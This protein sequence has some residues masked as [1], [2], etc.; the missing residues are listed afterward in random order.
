MDKK[1]ANLI[2]LLDE[3]FNRFRKMIYSRFGINLTDAKKSLFHTR[4]QKVLN[5]YQFETFSQYYNFLLSQKNSEALSI[6]VNQITTNHTHF[7]RESLH[8]DYFV[9]SVLPEVL[10][11]RKGAVNL[12]FWS[13]GCS[14]GEEPYTLSILLHNFFMKTSTAHSAAILATDISVKALDL[15][16][17]G[18]YE[19]SNVALLPLRLR[20]NYLEKYSDDLWRVTNKV[21]KLVRFGRFNLMRQEFPFQKKFH[22]IFC[23]NVM[24]YFD[25]RTKQKLAQKFY[26]AIE[27]GGYLFIGHSETLD[28]SS[29]P[30]T[31]VRPAV[32]R[33]G[34]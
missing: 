29:T 10:K 20:T 27:P 12:R 4:L 11:G 32:Y 13:A 18:I 8:F 2:P 33:K 9:N 31:Y 26:D 3:E 6:L 34:E 21:R 22:A 14:S 7:Y 24:I 17:A 23:R 15:A 30:F 28:R 25:N 1:G 19:D 5:G 16:K